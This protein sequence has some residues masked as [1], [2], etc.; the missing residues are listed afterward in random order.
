MDDRGGC[1]RCAGTKWPAIGFGDR[2]GEGQPAERKRHEAV[3]DHRLE[4]VIGSDIACLGSQ[5]QADRGEPDG[6]ARLGPDSPREPIEPKTRRA[7]GQNENDKE[8]C[9]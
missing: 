3:E 2:R 5:E 4:E 9:R 1:D 7:E 8:P 6:G